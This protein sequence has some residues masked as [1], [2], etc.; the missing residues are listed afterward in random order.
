MQDREHRIVGMRSFH[1]CV[2]PLPAGLRFLPSLH[3]WRTH[4]RVRLAP[5]HCAVHGAL[6]GAHDCGCEQTN[7]AGEAPCSQCTERSCCSC[8]PLSLSVTDISLAFSSLLVTVIPL[9]SSSLSDADTSLTF[10]LFGT[11]AVVNGRT[12]GRCQCDKMP[13]WHQCSSCTYK[14]VDS[15]HLERHTKVSRRLHLCVMLHL[16]C[17]MTHCMAMILAGTRPC[18]DVSPTHASLA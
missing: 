11:T 18:F 9:T 17:V 7:A 15:G 16:A 8:D 3:S 14:S 5:S 12:D 10:S 6:S 13:I 1:S 2:A 4:R